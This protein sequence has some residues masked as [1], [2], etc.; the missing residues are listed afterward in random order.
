MSRTRTQVME[1]LPPITCPRC[2]GV[3]V[4]GQNI[5]ALFKF[6]H[7]DVPRPHPVLSNLIT[8]RGTISTTTGESRTDLSVHEQLQQR[9]AMGGPQ[10]RQALVAFEEVFVNALASAL[11]AQLRKAGGTDGSE[12]VALDNDQPKG[13]RQTR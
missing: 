7:Y 12:P 1:G 13:G 5:G 10:E 9:A 4:P 6:T 11:V 3:L 8:L 2:G